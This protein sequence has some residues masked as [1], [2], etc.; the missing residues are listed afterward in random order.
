MPAY[1]HR[2]P[3][4]RSSTPSS[5]GRCWSERQLNRTWATSRSISASCGASLMGIARDIVELEAR[6]R[7]RVDVDPF[8]PL[9]TGG[10][11]STP[12][13]AA[14]LA[15]ATATPLDAAAVVRLCLQVLRI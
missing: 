4:V 7:E 2:K 1:S 10:L 15:R 3:H 13:F 9:S 11:L 12:E 8:G 14:M 5:I 6:L